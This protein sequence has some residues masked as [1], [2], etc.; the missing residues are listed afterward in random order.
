MTRLECLQED[1]VKKFIKQEE[2][3]PIMDLLLKDH[4]VLW[5]SFMKF[6]QKDEKR[7]ITKDQWNMTLKFLVFSDGDI[8]VPFLSTSSLASYSYK[9]SCD[10]HTIGKFDPM[11]A[12]PVLVDEWVEWVEEVGHEAAGIVTSKSASS[13]SAAATTIDLT[14]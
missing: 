3:L 13:A 7:L 6:L 5:A 8:G 10:N 4:F 14:G 12:W 9:L 1:E 2:A 11:D